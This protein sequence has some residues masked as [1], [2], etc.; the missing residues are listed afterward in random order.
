MY[1]SN[2]FRQLFSVFIR[3]VI[4]LLYVC[5]RHTFSTVLISTKSGV[6][7]NLIFS[8]LGRTLMLQY[9]MIELIGMIFPSTLFFLAL[10]S[11]LK[12]FSLFE[13]DFGR[14]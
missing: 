11:D 2:K 8:L 7:V 5:I 10:A 9:H 6:K 13:E 12:G 14:L 4:K 3:K 1:F